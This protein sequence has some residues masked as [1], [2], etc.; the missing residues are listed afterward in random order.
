M[1]H[2]IT[3][4]ALLALIGGPLASAQTGSNPSSSGTTNP[5]PTSTAIPSRCCTCA[6]STGVEVCA[7]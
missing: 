4:I 7:K 3:T 1:R 2:L 6:T 5:R